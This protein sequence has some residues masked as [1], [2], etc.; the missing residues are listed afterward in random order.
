MQ[1]NYLDTSIFLKNKK[2]K[3]KILVIVLLFSFCCLDFTGNASI[4]N[5]HNSLIKANFKVFSWWRY[6]F[7]IS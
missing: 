2:M 6:D 5:F 7:S 3:L 1:M 4:K